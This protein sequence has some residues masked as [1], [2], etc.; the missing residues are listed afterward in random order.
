MDNDPQHQPPPESERTVVRPR[1]GARA[2]SAAPVP[3][4]IADPTPAQTA[5]DLRAGASLE[6]LPPVGDNP[7]L[8]CARPLLAVVPQIRGTLEHPDP[9]SLKLSLIHI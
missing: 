7:L 5:P 8:R 4:P 6:P 2:G 9:A 1:P 3:P